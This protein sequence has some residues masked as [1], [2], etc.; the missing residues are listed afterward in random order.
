MRDEPLLV[1]AHAN[2]DELWLSI[3]DGA[4]S[5]GVFERCEGPSMDGIT[6]AECRKLAA[7]LLEA[8]AELEKN[9]VRY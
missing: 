1:I 8:A 6:P 7:G 2:G 3:Q 4:A 5:V 9:L